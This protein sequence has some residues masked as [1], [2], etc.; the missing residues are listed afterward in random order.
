VPS[1][2]PQRLRLQGADHVP[3]HGPLF[4]LV[5]RMTSVL[6]KI[7]KDVPQNVFVVRLS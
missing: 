5:F 6:R 2:R 7:C 3:T 4:R 1:T